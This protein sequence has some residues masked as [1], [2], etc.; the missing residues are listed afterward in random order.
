MLLILEFFL[1][2]TYKQGCSNAIHLHEM[3]NVIGFNVEIYV[4]SDTC[5]QGRKLHEYVKACM[6]EAY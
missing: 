3:Q 1:T 4:K 5:E 2:I 6:N